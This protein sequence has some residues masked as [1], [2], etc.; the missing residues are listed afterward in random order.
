M[1][2]YLNPAK[3]WVLFILALSL[4]LLIMVLVV[5]GGSLVRLDDFLQD[6]LESVRTPDVVRAAFVFTQL[7][8]IYVDTT[9]T[10]LCVA[11][12]IWR[13]EFLGSIIFLVVMYG[14]GAFTHG[15]KYV[16]GRQR[17]PSIEGY[18]DPTPSFPSDHCAYTTA[19]V[20]CLVLLVVPLFSG[21]RWSRLVAVFLMLLPVLVALCRMLLSMHYLSDTLAGIAIGLSWALFVVLIFQRLRGTGRV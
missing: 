21:A 16:V 13:R 11:L 5:S 12:L 9:V 18:T 2:T 1:Q 8:G 6:R 15:F 17:P 10:L 4:F 14:L 7:G 20:T 19:L 3:G